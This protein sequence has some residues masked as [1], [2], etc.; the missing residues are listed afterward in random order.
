[1]SFNKYIDPFYKKA[2][3]LS[4]QFDDATINKD[5][6]KLHSLID[7]AK[8][9]VQY[10]DAASQA[11]IYYSIGTVYG[12]IASIDSSSNDEL[13][14]K[15][16]Y[17]FRKSIIHIQFEELNDKKY[18]P[19]VNALKINLYTNYGNTLDHCGRKIAAIEQYKK[20]LS[21]RDK[22]GM[23]LGNLGI[24]YTHYGMIVADPVHKDY[25]HHFAYNLL[26]R[27]IMSDDPNTYDQAKNYFNRA[28]DGYDTEYVNQILSV[29]LDIP[30]Y[31]YCNQGELQY[32]QWALENNLFLNPLNDLPVS[33]FC[34][35]ADVVQLPAMLAEI[36]DKPIFHGMFNQF[37]Q[38]FIFAR[39]Q[40]YCGQ[41]QSDEVHFAD[42]DTYLLN[43]ADYPQYSIRI[44][45]LKS[46]FKTLYSLLDKVAYFMNS[47]FKLG[48]KERDVSF[49]SIWNSEKRGKNGYKY[50]STLN[51][52]S[53][54]SL[55]SIYWI[56]KDFYEEFLDSPNP[57]AQRI[58]DIRNALEHKY[59][60]VTWDL[61]PDRRTGDIDDLA[62]YVP[63]V[64]LST[65]TFKLLK[66]IREVIICLSLAVGIEEENHKNELDP[67]KMV[68]PISLMAYDDEWKI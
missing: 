65:E 5:I 66:L 21:I 2:K 18:F 23:A 25:F 33:E 40:Y 10:E 3:E 22:F 1:M 41:Q 30:Q 20:A 48:I 47:Y 27:A 43:F 46:A 36:D 17:Y 45:M 38:E 9:L 29:P 28:I 59:V 24:A 12:D 67:S 34:F 60:K 6:D 58:R 32:R 61:F 8:E 50:K 54:F 63:E 51:P 42:K 26:N 7:Q 68:M 56:S 16:L 39:Y 57:Q 44:E 19:Y 37:K 62:F 55:A 11:Q 15:Q 14:K 13:I 64:E 35:A 53:N 52:K 49:H 31:N 4:W